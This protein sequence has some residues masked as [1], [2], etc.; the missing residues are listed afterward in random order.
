MKACLVIILLCTFSSGSFAQKEHF[1]GATNL[2]PGITIA[3]APTAIDQLASQLQKNNS[4]SKDRLLAIHSWVARNIDYDTDSMYLINWKLSEEAVIEETMRRRRGVCQNYSIIFNALANKCGITSFVV[5]G[6]TRQNG[7]SDKTGHTWVAVKINDEWAFCD[8]TWDKDNSSDLRYFFV[9][10]DQFIHTHMP[11]DPLWQLLPYEVTVE[12]F[13]NGNTGKKI[14][15]PTVDF[16][17]RVDLYISQ[18]PLQRLEATHTRMKKN[19]AASQLYRNQ[20][21]YVNMKISIFYEEEDLELYNAAVGHFNSATK[22]LNEFLHYRNNGL[23][24]SKSYVVL[25]ATLDAVAQKINQA[26]VSIKGMGLKM[27]NEACNPS[28]L[29]EHL[30]TLDK[31]L[32]QEKLFLQH[33]FAQN[34][35]SQKL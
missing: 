21:A 4:N 7:R 6:F 9:K 32:N 3:Q 20:V 24:P 8:P 27:P 1:N 34:K 14:N 28:L 5:D 31:R 11:F 23:L 15:K 10:P 17:D 35:V 16:K 33:Y 22:L 26:H 12:D 2:A 25:S 30:V 18:S 13:N 19:A 29:E